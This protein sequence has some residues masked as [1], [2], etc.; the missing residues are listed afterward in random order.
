MNTVAPENIVSIDVLKDASAAAIYGT[1]GANG[2]IIITTK[3]GKRDEKCSVTYSSYAS[4]SNFAN[5]LDFMTADDVRNGLTGFKDQGSDTDW[6]DA[7]SRTAFTHNHNFNITGGNKTTTYS[8]DFSYR[9]AQGV[10]L[11]TYNNEMKM[12]M[13]LSHWM[14]N[15]MLKVSFDLQKSWHKNSVTNASSGSDV[16]N[17]YHQALVRNPTAPIKNDDGSWNEDFS[18][19]YYYNPV[20]IIKELDGTYKTEDTRMTAN[21]TFE[22][23]KGWQTNL[24][25]G[26]SR[27]NTHTST[28]YT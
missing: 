21:L 6:V 17:I 12:R 9:N 27:Y 25:L 16:S 24:M 26:T 11:D 19:S 4:I 5:K 7:I 20:E 1:R 10:I 22:P 2:V 13:N 28:F 14:L 18:A 23:I 3:S 8:A 15:D